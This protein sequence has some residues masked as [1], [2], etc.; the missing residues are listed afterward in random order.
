MVRK[1]QTPP[2][3]KNRKLLIAVATVGVLLLTIVGWPRPSAK[4]ANVA[5][6]FLAYTNI[7]NGGRYRTYALFSVTNL[8]D[9]DVRSLGTYI[10]S[11]G[12][13]VAPGGHNV[14]G[15][16]HNE[17]IRSGGAT[18]LAIDEPGALVDPGQWRLTLV[19]ARYGT[20]E[21]IQEQWRQ[22]PSTNRVVLAI[23]G[24]LEDLNN[25][26]LVVA[27]SDWIEPHPQKRQGPE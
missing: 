18:V 21:W 23:G 5:V 16:K 27:V 24:V 25:D 10:Q 12:K 22:V 17:V 20:K 14:P 2:V 6:S 9:V 15:L 1:V 13:F 7:L 19:F 26:G 11:G 3:F 4:P 8:S